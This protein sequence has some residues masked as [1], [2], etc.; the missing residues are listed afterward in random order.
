LAGW[1]TYFAGVWPS[2]V[3]TSAGWAVFGCAVDGITF[4]TLCRQGTFRNSD[5]QRYNNG[6]NRDGEQQFKKVNVV[7]FRPVW[8]QGF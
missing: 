4:R 7:D 8:K 2:G 3:G 1:Q 6:D 5:A